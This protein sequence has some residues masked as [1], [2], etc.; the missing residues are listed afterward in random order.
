MP[1]NSSPS[2][3]P[4]GEPAFTQV[5]LTG[6]AD[7]VAQLMEHLSGVSQV[8]FGPV[9]Q[10]GRGGDVSCT[11][12]V[13]THPSLEPV[14]D[15]QTVAV[16]VQTVLEVEPGTLPGLPDPAAARHVE[17]SVTTVLQALPDVRK[18]SSRYVSAVGLPTARE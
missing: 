9:L 12:K 10:P 1:L 18:A 8:I 3:A 16:T 13:V 6:P 2:P 17:A 4:A 15:G 14:A 11:A 5:Q 7:A